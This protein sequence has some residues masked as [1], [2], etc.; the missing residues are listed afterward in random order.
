M[1]TTILLLALAV[2]SNVCALDEQTNLFIFESTG[3]ISVHLHAE[4]NHSC[5]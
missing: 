1:K 4:M 5:I 2:S 3:E